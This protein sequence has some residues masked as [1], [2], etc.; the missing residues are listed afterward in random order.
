[1]ASKEV[2]LTEDE[3]R[4]LQDALVELIVSNPANQDAFEGPIQKQQAK[5]LLDKLG[6]TL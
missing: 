5:D 2:I 6:E 1:M 3:I 4:L